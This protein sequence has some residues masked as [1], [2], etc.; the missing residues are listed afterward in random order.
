MLLFVTT[1]KR[2]CIPNINFIFVKHSIRIGVVRLG[3]GRL[4]RSFLGLPP[5]LLFLLLLL[6]L[7]LVFLCV[8]LVPALSLLTFHSLN[9]SASICLLLGR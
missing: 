6:A 3:L 2:V 4:L 7:G 8:V 9:F 5:F 1:Q